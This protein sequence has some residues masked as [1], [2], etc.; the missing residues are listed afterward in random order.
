MILSIFILNKYTFSQ[1]LIS[2]TN[3]IVLLTTIVLTATLI[4][5]Q[6]KRKEA[7]RKLI[8]GLTIGGSAILIM[9]NS[10]S[11]ETGLIFDSRSVLYSI[12]T[13]YYGLIPALIGG[14]IGIV[15]RISIP[16]TS[17]ASALL[18]IV[19]PIM[20][21][22][23]WRYFFKPYEKNKK[24]LFLL[25]FSFISQ[26]FVYILFIIT[27]YDKETLA[28]LSVIYLLVFPIGTYIIGLLLERQDKTR[29]LNLDNR[30]KNALLQSSYD[31]V[32][33][34]EMFALSPDYKY[35]FYNKFHEEQMLKYYNIQIKPGMNFV[36]QLEHPEMKERILTN[37]NKAF[38]GDIVYYNGEVENNHGKYIEDYINPIINDG[39]VTGVT[40]FTQD[41]TERVE[42]H[43]NYLYL[44]YNDVL[45]GLHNRR[46]YMEMRDKIDIKSNLPI[47]VIQAD[48]NG[49]KIMNDA[50]GHDA[51]DELLLLAANALKKHFKKEQIFRIGGDEFLVLLPQTTYDQ[52][53]LIID[54]VA[55]SLENETINGMEVSISYGIA[56]KVTTEQDIL[57]ITKLAEDRM[58]KNKLF[59]VSS[60]RYESIR[61]ILNTLYEKDPDSERHSKRVSEI[62]A[63]IG[64]KL[65]MARNEINLLEAISQLHDIGK[66]TIDDH[67][68]HKKGPLTD[69]EWKI[70]KKHPEIGYR[71]ISTSPKYAD[72][73]FDI[74]SHHERYDGSGY[75]LGLS[76][77]EIPIRARIIAVADAFDAMISDRAY[78]KRLSFDEALNELINNSGTQFDPEIVKAVVDNVDEFKKAIKKIEKI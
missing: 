14:L 31:S 48:I 55:S 46:H 34:M 73:A 23:F 63:F 75:P 13:L 33:N 67:I 69:E 77:K 22:L 42:Y 1:A 53:E 30:Q 49:L 57:V 4:N 12:T 32:I 54:E 76:G 59:S 9:L 28:H 18:S 11:F 15:F 38:Q 41:I 24:H 62:C 7:L 65:N 64:H 37:L 40:V 51:G 52:A 21:G 47:T 70:V 3:N 10:W 35:L 8:L 58:Y 44:S 36:N 61:T 6:S 17:P 2:L 43:N 25:L 66:I 78:R 50:F 56:T 20:I 27:I 72:I 45:T 26:L 60:H 74:L 39:V 29:Q 5:F 71:I 19:I 68:I 16:S